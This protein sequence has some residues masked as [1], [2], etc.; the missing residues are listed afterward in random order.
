M[1]QAAVCFLTVESIEVFNVLT[2]GGISAAAYPLEF[3]KWLRI[4]LYMI[5]IG[6]I[7]YL[8][9][10]YLFGKAAVSRMDGVSGAGGRRGCS[11]ML[12]A[13]PWQAGAIRNRNEA[14]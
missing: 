6:F 14:Q 3:R 11:F 10:A 9:C 4:F 12:G 7:N 1:M 13:V 2:F 8:P 5:P